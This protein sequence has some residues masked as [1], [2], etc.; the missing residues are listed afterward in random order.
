MGEG[1]GDWEGEAD[2]GKERGTGLTND[3]TRAVYVGDGVLVSSAEEAGRNV[4]EGDLVLVTHPSKG[5]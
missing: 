1:K 5:G 4:M 2:L 3:G